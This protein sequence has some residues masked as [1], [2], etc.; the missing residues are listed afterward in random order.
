MVGI[1]KDLE[2]VLTK[3]DIIILVHILDKPDVAF[4]K[5]KFGKILM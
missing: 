1:K 5:E 4:F 2:L 3:G